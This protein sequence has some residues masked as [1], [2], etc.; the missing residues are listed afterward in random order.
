MNIKTVTITGADDSISPKDLIPLQRS[1]PFVEWGILV[2]YMSPRYRFPTETWIRALR[3]ITDL[4]LSCHVCGRWVRD[5]CREGVIATELMEILPMFKRVQLNFHA[6]LH[7]IDT[8]KFISALRQMSGKQII[9]QLDNVNNDILKTAQEADINAVPLFD[10]SGGAGIL[11][12]KWPD[13]VSYCGYAGGLSPENVTDQLRR[14]HEVAGNSDVWIDVETKV[15]SEND[16]KFDLH[17]VRM[18]LA[19]VD[20][21]KKEMRV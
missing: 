13:P 4:N 11:P 5:L 18:F 17:K 20:R 9:F 10:T 15:R 19:Y 12:E 16:A 14:I 21:Y 1:Y 3:G 6:I 7:T 2:S 8:E